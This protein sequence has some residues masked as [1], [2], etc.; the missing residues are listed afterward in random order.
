M[1]DD[2]ELLN[3]TI[4]A[5]EILKCTKTLNN[6]KSPGIN[7]IINEYIKNSQSKRLPFYVPSFN[8]ILKSGMYPSQWS[9]GTI[10][11]IYKKKGERV[12]PENYRQITLLSCIGK[13]F[14]SVLNNR[15]T[16]FLDEYDI[17]SENQAG[18]RSG[19][20]TTDHVFTLNSILDL[21]KHYILMEK[22][23]AST[24]RIDFWGKGYVGNHKIF[25]YLILIAYDLHQFYSIIFA[26]F[27]LRRTKNELG[28]QA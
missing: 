15:L 13:L 19:Y 9:I 23:L 2:D 10:K 3:S 7:N 4:T 28:S 5:D 21:F 20:F 6:S 8:T 17:L 25:R 14:T 27:S 11:P 24:E 12:N 1:E 18:F 22:S 16:K 26:A